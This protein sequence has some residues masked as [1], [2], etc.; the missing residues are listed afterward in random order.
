MLWVVGGPR[1]I[2]PAKWISTTRFLTR[3]QWVCHSPLLGATSRRLPTV[4]PTSG[5]RAVTD[6]T[7]LLSWTRWKSLA[8]SES[9]WVALA[10]T[11]GDCNGNGD[12]LGNTYCNRN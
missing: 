6:L 4:L 3:G 2:R 5:Y 7:G 9:L 8:A 10:N 12:C 1:Q 11:H